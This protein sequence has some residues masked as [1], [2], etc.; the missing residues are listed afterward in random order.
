MRPLTFTLS[1][2]EINYLGRFSCGL[3]LSSSGRGAGDFCPIRPRARGMS[4]I[5]A[6]AAMAREAL[7]KALREGA[8]PRVETIDRVW[9]ALG[10]KPVAVPA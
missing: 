6:S 8:Q 1:A 9:A 4:G 2:N 7:Y 3:F 5:A 10:V